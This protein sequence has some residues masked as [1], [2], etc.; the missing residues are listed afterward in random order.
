MRRRSGRAERV[1]AAGRR[2][3]ARRRRAAQ[4]GSGQRSAA[5]A[6]RLRGQPPRAAKPPRHSAAARRQCG[7]R[8]A[9][10]AAQRRRG[11][12]YPHHPPPRSE[13]DSVSRQ[14]LRPPP[15]PAASA[16]RSPPRQRRA[17]ERRGRY[18]ALA[19]RGVRMRVGGGRRPRPCAGGRVPGGDPAARACQHPWRQE[20]NRPAR[21]TLCRGGTTREGEIQSGSWRHLTAPLRNAWGVSTGMPQG[22]QL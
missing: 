12:A 10:T 14:C 13:A 20:K 17:C 22:P 21:R 3:G 1:Q 11:V 5:S 16:S 7:W 4:R 19:K 18:F 9:Q 15:P 2:P 8:L 6:S